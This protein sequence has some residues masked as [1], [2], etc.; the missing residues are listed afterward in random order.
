MKQ[1]TEAAYAKLNLTLDV[2]GL[3]SDGYHE[4]DMVM[5]S[6]SLC[7]TVTLTRRD[8]PGIV[9]Q[10]NAKLPKDE[11]NL[12]YAAALRF[13]E[14]LGDTQAGLHIALEKRIPVCAGT[15]GGS[16]DAAAVL[17]GLHRLYHAPF[18][19]EVLHD[20]GARVGSDVPYCVYGKTA[21]AQGRGEIL[22]P[23]PSLPPC[24]L[25]LCKPAFSISTPALFHQID[26]CNTLRRPAT[27]AMCAA[28]VAGDLSA[29]ADALGNVFEAV[30][31]PSQQKTIASIR[32]TLC[33]EGALGACMSGTGPTVFG[34]FDAESAATRAAVRL[35]QNYPNVFLTHPV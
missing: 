29:V 17:R 12:A 10:G 34:L 5:Q 13:F 33:Q 15:A 31:T 27:D 6:V 2:R 26:V 22:S 18:P 11:R 32:A 8:T 20:I 4:M 16:S 19:L 30:L 25:V 3:R 24:F 23:L 1:V 21:R 14:Y 7:D 28:L 9:L 35:R